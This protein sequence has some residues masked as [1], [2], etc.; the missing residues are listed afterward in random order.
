MEMNPPSSPV[1]HTHTPPRPISGERLM[2]RS[3]ATD[4]P[5]VYV[6]TLPALSPAAVGC[7]LLQD[8]AAGMLDSQARIR[9]HPHQSRE[10][11]S[12][13]HSMRKGR[14]RGVRDGDREEREKKSVKNFRRPGRGL[15]LVGV[16]YFTYKRCTHATNM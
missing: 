10:L 15:S 3:M 8:F 4:Y 12:V 1:T 5:S 11:P 16:R 7:W 6:D 2:A 9:N 14:R 13:G